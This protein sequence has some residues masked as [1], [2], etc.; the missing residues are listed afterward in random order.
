MPGTAI[1]IGKATSLINAALALA[2]GYVAAVTALELLPRPAKSVQLTSPT[3][4]P[5]AAGNTAQA[6]AG[7][8]A[9]A[10]L[11]GTAKIAPV[12]KVVEKV[13]EDAPD[14][15]LNL[16]LHGVLAYNPA[17][18][19]LAMISSGG[20]QETVY[21]IGDEII[22]NTTLRAVYPDRVIIRRSGKDETLRLPEQVAQLSVVSQPVA[23]ESNDQSNGQ[24][25]GQALP[26]SA[27]E[28]RQQ[29]LQQPTMM[30]DLVALRP[31][32]RNGQQVG[33]RIQP[34]RDP[35]L[36]A[37]FGIQPGD[38]ITSINGITLDNNRNSLTA[39]G[40]LRTASSADL[41]ILRGG[42]ETPLSIS[43]Q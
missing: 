21:A 17:D 13:Q 36:L 16:T 4:S 30:A 15:R 12:K 34:K 19:A 2:I 22:G 5:R 33:Y 9:A 37:E 41:M 7:E 31:Y 10:H 8:I 32:K 18:S 43:L 26:S 23:P 25:S 20:G 29:L 14:T 42:V 40:Q 27:S 38:V 6:T 35:Q 39:L 11:F 1:N 24:G 3:A 28:L